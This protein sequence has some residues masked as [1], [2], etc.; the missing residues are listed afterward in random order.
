MKRYF[1]FLTFVAALFLVSCG[2]TPTP[3][4]EVKVEKP[5]MVIIEDK[6]TL[7]GIS[8]PAWVANAL[9]STVA[10]E[11]MPDY[12]GKYAFIGE[13][14]GQDI[15]ALKT[16]ADNF[17][18]QPLIAARVD[19][20][21]EAQFKGAQVGGKD[22]AGEYYQ[23]YVATKTSINFTGLVKEGDWW[24]RFKDSPDSRNEKYRYYILYTVDKK[25]LDEQIS[26]YLDE[27]ANGIQDAKEK[28]IVLEAKD[29]IKNGGLN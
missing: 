4:S 28:E 23:R 29:I 17:V 7:V 19:S 8:S 18:I 9:Q 6:G 5:K 15:G 26:R 14:E 20:T 25:L 21:V 24:I 2:S 16:W 1:V 10:V 11:K 22:L 27:K 12:A 3:K 13:E